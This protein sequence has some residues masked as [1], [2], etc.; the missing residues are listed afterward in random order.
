MVYPNYAWILYGW[1]SE[2][3]WRSPDAAV[4]CSED[5]LAAVLERALVVQQYPITD[6][7]SHV[8]VGGV[9]S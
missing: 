8:A 7:T 4:N 3:W 9:V 1:Y 5:E 2:E 6:N